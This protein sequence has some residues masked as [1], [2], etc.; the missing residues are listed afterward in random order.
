MSE[1]WYIANER[2]KHSQLPEPITSLM[3]RP[4]P[5]GWWG[6]AGSRLTHSD[7]A[8]KTKCG[9]FYG[10]IGLKNAV[11]PPSVRRIGEYSFSGTDL[12]EVRIGRNCSYSDTSFPEDCTVSFYE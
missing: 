1:A 8:E 5:P 12:T 10:C 6:M 7:L 11:I 2:H 4:Y 3:V 9:A